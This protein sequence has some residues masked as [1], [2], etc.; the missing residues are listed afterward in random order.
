MTALQ[1]KY[2]YAFEFAERQKIIH[3]FNKEV[4]MAGQDWFHRFMKRNKELTIRKPEGLSRARIDGMKREK[5][6]KFFETLETVVD[7][8]NLRRRPEC[9]YMWTKR[10]SRSI[11]DHPTL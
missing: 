4:G 11:I 2:K 10:G 5:V 9:V 1:Y 7:K 8:T 3:K 6:A